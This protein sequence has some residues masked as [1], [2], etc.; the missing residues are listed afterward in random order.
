MTAECGTY[1]GYQRHNRHGEDAC[2]PCKA[3]N[4][5]YTYEYLADH[6]EQYTAMKSRVK[7]RNRAL[8]RLGREYPARLSELL[9]EELI[10]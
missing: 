6:P 2:D 8:R 9:A 3:A 1:G 5:A 7:A 10:R 4:L